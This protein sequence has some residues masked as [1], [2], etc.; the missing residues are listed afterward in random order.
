VGRPLS[1][2]KLS[3]DHLPDLEP[4]LLEVLD[5]V[6][7]KEFDVRDKRGRWYSLR[8][9]P[10]MTHENKIDG[11]VVL[12]V[13]IDGIKRGQSLRA[14][15]ERYRALFNLGPIAIYSCDVSGT[16]QEYNH[17]AA[18]LWGRQP[19]PGDTDERFCGSF[20]MHLP[21]GTLLPHDQCPMADVLSGKYRLRATWKSS[22]SAP[23]ALGL[24]SS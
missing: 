6:S 13:D 15:E 24:P 23:T 7:T 9:R 21:D 16:I 14:S 4:L 2:I 18:E 22:S 5:T 3:L 20:K 8:L 10:Y 17:R 19:R 11:I 12:L 1:N